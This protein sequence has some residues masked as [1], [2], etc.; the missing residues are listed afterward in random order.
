MDATGKNISNIKISR[1]REFFF[2]KHWVE[3]LN[4]VESNKSKIDFFGLWRWEVTLNRNAAAERLRNAYEFSIEGNR[5]ILHTLCTN[6]SQY[7]QLCTTKHYFACHCCWDFI[8]SYLG[9]TVW[10]GANAN[11]PLKSFN[12]SHGNSG[13]KRY[14]ELTAQN[15][16][17]E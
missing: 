16:R 8:I 7:T 12:L 11:S 17:L 2:W 14:F 6:F 15:V 5:D 10:A 9:L 1:I 3:Y 13:C 4:S